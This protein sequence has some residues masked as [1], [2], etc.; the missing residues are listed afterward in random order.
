MT[1]LRVSTD[2]ELTRQLVTHRNAVLGMSGS[3]KSNA[4]VVIAEEMF[5]EELPWIAVDP[6]GD[7]HGMRSSADGKRPGLA[8]PIFGGDHGDLP[9][10]PTNG[11]RM[12]ELVAE[13]KI[14]GIFDLSGF[15]TDAQRARFMAD[16]GRALF[17][18][19]RTPIHIFCDECH[20]YMPQPGA[21]GRLEGPAA[22]CVGVWKRILTQGRQ[23]GIGVTLCSQRTAHVN[24]TCLYQCETLLAFRTMGKLDRKAIQDWVD[25]VGDARALLEA[26]PRLADGEAFV[27]SPM[28]LRLETRVLFR[29]RQ[30]FDSGRTPEVGETVV[31]PKLAELDLEALRA[32]LV[33]H[34]FA[35]VGE[36]EK[37]SS[38]KPN[39]VHQQ[40]AEMRGKVAE[41]ERELAEKPG[42]DR[43]KA[44]ELHLAV[45]GALSGATRA[46]EHAEKRVTTLFEEYFAASGGTK[47][48]VLEIAG[49]RLPILKSAKEIEDHLR[50]TASATNGHR[51]VKP[52]NGAG[53]STLSKVA[54]ALLTALAQHGDLSL[55]QAAIIAGY[56]PNA[57]NTRN[58]AGEL[59][60]GGYVE[61]S[62]ERIAITDK[63][64]HEMRDA[65]RLPTGKR[66]AEY[67]YTKLDR[68]PRLILSE[69][70]GA[71]PGKLSLKEAAK[72]AG[73]APDAGNT[74]NA[75][76]RLRT[77][78]LV[79]G[80]NAGMQADRR[81]V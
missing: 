78:C 57:G 66:L 38:S 71:Y 62:N 32:E 8:V 4:A 73:L 2:L 69:V 43:D 23:R 12:G 79:H 77:L 74:R 41:L 56:A 67:W 75:A 25:Q 39:G 19:R 24:K 76:G 35:E 64:K 18:G 16:F 9:L 59:R 63:G 27:W 42:F 30:T 37:P 65:P 7:W 68:A 49:R 31:A 11:K 61:G 10:A 51:D 13:G 54:A 1:G 81:L 58:G 47:P 80:G 21:G 29:R 14:T 50:H 33:D 28:R 72:G 45:L 60:S 3:G 5:R 70:I 36:D 26:L 46:I 40:L 6:K 15:E 34:E 52:S 53:A 55:V 20:E 48:A 22:E 17:H 44:G